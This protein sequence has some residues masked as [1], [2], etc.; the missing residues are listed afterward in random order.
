[1]ASFPAP[2]G[3]DFPNLE[4]ALTEN[5]PV[6][7]TLLVGFIGLL[8]VTIATVDTKDVMHVVSYRPLIVTCPEIFEAPGKNFTLWITGTDCLLFYL[9]VLSIIYARMSQY[10]DLVSDTDLAALRLREPLVSEEEKR[11]DRRRDSY[12]TICMF[13]FNTGI[14][15]LPLALIPFTDKR[16][17]QSLVID[18]VIVLLAYSVW[19]LKGRLTRSS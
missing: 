10:R 3:Q 2:F 18:L 8:F 17:R 12:V 16:S 11:L 14:S 13:L 7:C 1:M 19:A 6:L 9:A 5:V 15:S 4:K